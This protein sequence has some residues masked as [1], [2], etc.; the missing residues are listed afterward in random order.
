MRNMLGRGS[1]EARTTSNLV[2]G[3]K[4]RSQVVSESTE[5]GREQPLVRPLVSKAQLTDVE[6]K[7]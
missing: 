6:A 2:L 7:G 1:G 3:D 4:V 5:Q